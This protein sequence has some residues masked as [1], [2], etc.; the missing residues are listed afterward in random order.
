MAGLKVVGYEPSEK[1]LETLKHA[2]A[3]AEKD[4]VSSPARAA[5]GATMNDAEAKSKSLKAANEFALETVGVTQPLNDRSGRYAGKVLHETDHHVVQDVGRKVAV[6]HD[7]SAF[8]AADLKKAIERGG[9]LRVQYDK[10]RAA[11]DA[12]KDRAQSHSR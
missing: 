3:S 6:V 5:S 2:R 9:T 11:I 12:G 8:N 10:G 4:G 1:D 7:K